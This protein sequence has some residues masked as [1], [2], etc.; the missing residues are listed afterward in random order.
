ML[1]IAQPTATPSITAADGVALVC[2]Q[3]VGNHGYPN[4]VVFSVSDVDPT[5]QSDFKEV[6]VCSI[7]SI[8]LSLTYVVC[9]N[10]QL[11]TEY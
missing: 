4:T 1:Y 6:S 7:P 3:V 9:R 11:R 10:I 2:F 5:T 8:H